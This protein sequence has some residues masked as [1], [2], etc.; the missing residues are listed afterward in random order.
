MIFQKPEQPKVWLIR[1]WQM[2]VM[3]TGRESWI[4]GRMAHYQSQHIQTIFSLKAIPV[5]KGQCMQ[6]RF[7]K[8]TANTEKVYH[9]YCDS[10][11]RLILP[12]NYANRKPLY[13][14]SK[15]EL[16]VRSMNQEQTWNRHLSSPKIGML[17]VTTESC[18]I[19]D[20]NFSVSQTLSKFR[21]QE[22]SLYSNA[23]RFAFSDVLNA[24]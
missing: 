22:K 14:E 23:L 21:Q 4:K 11:L 13:F 15:H 2:V 7:R 6:V 18:L 16:W 20:S 1:N 10:S 24:I 17:K 5:C 8:S 12:E 3:S 19:V 9:Y